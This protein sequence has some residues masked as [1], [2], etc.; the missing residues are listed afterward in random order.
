MRLKIYNDS[1]Y[2]S[3]GKAIRES[4]SA[5]GAEIALPITGIGGA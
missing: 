2:I 4:Q 3:R 1:R 5:S